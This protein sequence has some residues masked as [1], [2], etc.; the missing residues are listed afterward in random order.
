MLDARLCIY[1]CFVQYLAAVLS[2][3][4]CLNRNGVTLT[5]EEIAE[6]P[7]YAGNLVIEDWHQGG[8]FGRFMR[9]ARLLDM[10]IPTTRDIIPPL[11][12][13]QLVKMTANQM[14]LQG[15]QIHA[16]PATGATL[17]FLQCWV[18]RTE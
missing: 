6:S 14:T 13:P 8:R 7:R 2:K 18:V 15:Y 17:Q 16:D 10:T 11:F 4:I 9:Q 3:V 12:D 5:A 1:C